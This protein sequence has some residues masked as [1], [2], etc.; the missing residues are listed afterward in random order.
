M[1]LTLAAQFN[2]GFYQRIRL[3]ST[4]DEVLFERESKAATTRAPGWF[5]QLAPIASDPGTAQVSNGWRPVGHVEV[6]SHSAFAY[7]ELWRGSLRSALA[8][9]LV[10]VLAGLVGG[11]LVG[12][13]RKPL[14]ATVK[15]AKALVEGEFITLPEP[16]VPELRRLTQAMNA[17]VGRLR[18]TFQAQTEQLETLRRQANLDRLTGL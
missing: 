5:V 2:T 12:R 6:V 3:L 10:G 7:D 11:V 15:Q 4:D 16:Q 13:I 1:E 14:N 17:M 9:G 8:L 18:V